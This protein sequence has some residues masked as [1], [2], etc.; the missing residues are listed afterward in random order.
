MSKILVAYFSASGNTKR[1]AEKI[2]ELAGGDIYEIRPRQEYT[3]EDL[4][5]NI[6]DCRTTVEM[7]NKTFR[8]Q[9]AD[10]YADIGEYDTILLGFPVWWYVAPT[11]L[12][13]FLESYDFSG[14]K[15]ILFATSGSSGVDKA[16]EDLK[17][18]LPDNAVILAGGALRADFTDRQAEELF[19]SFD[20]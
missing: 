1:L 16:V 12:N 19:N 17:P 8:P 20:I 11:L 14:K 4:D 6:P 18:S 13:T 10:K 5:Y 7:N 15:I 2:A 3:K 9:L